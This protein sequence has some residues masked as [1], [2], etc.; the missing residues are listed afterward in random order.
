M[1]EDEQIACAMMT[2]LQIGDERKG[3][4]WKGGEIEGEG[5]TEVNFITT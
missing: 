3:R 2:S 5:G 4:E 1:T